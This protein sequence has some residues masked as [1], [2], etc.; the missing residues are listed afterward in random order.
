M[1]HLPDQSPINGGSFAERDLQRHIILI[2][3]VAETDRMPD[4]H[5]SF[6]RTEPYK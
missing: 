4:L 6:S 2:Y 1:G 5:G 3:R